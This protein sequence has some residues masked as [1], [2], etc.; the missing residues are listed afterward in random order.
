MPD[1]LILKK[2]TSLHQPILQLEDLQRFII[3]RHNFNNIRYTVNTQKKKLQELIEKVAK[4]GKKKR[5][6]T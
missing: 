6:P 3:D 5:L 2:V 1:L 4:K